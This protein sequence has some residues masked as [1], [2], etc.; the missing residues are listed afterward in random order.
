MA[1]SSGFSWWR[2][3]NT[4]AASNQATVSKDY[5]KTGRNG[6]KDMKPAQPVTENEFIAIIS[7]AEAPLHLPN[8]ISLALEVDQR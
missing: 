4:L 3:I 8:F 2:H 6:T 1:D 7:L 5:F